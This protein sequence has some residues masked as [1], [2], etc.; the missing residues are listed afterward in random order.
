M[1]AC[2]FRMKYPHLLDGAIAA[3]GALTQDNSWACAQTGTHL[4]L[5]VPSQL[6]VSSGAPP[7]RGQQ[8]TWP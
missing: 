6:H 2:W 1:L 3:S 8:L 7:W 5:D 4:L